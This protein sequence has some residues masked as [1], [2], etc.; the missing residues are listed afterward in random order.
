MLDVT[1]S[2]VQSIEVGK[3]WQTF[4]VRRVGDRDPRQARGGDPKVSRGT[5]TVTV[6]DK[7]LVH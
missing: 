2:E 7:G 5:C 4:R 1:G 3:G 6:W